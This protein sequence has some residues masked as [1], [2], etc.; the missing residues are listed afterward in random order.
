MFFKGS[1]LGIFKCF[2][3]NFIDLQ[4]MSEGIGSSSIG[5]WSSDEGSI[6]TKLSRIGPE[7]SDNSPSKGSEVGSFGLP[8]E[9]ILEGLGEGS[10]GR[11]TDRASGSSQRVT[12]KNCRSFLRSSDLE[13]LR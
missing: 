8:E 1:F 5:S 11:P 9:P 4:K 10:P 7:Q 13:D 6:E 3:S 12:P 2:F